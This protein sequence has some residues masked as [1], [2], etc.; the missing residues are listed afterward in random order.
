MVVTISAAA[1]N[2]LIRSQPR[3]SLVFIC[4]WS[5]FFTSQYDVM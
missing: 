4:M 2:H 1:D 5:S 3:L